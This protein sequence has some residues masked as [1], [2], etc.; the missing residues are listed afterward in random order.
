VVKGK[1]DFN[2]ISFSSKAFKETDKSK[3]FLTRR[4]ETNRDGNNFS[5]RSDIKK[6]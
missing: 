6:S 2:Q 5:S 3:P 1:K 4:L